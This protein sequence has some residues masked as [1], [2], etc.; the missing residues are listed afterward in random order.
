MSHK[1]LGM[2]AS[3]N[4]VQCS[5][6]SALVSYLLLALISRVETLRIIYA[7]QLRV[8]AC[9]FTVVSVQ[10]AWRLYHRRCQPLL[11]IPFQ[12]V[13]PAARLLHDHIRALSKSMILSGYIVYSE[14]Q[15]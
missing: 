1:Y 14:A 11:C 7:A 2:A 9:T 8:L 4:M 10:C 3:C 5:V 13:S 6:A 15:Y 12:A